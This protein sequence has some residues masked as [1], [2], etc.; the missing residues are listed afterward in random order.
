VLQ[1]YDDNSRFTIKVVDIFKKSLLAE[2][3]FLN[4]Y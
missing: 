1:K 3:V 4:E 2:K